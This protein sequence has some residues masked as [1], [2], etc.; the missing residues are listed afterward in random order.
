MIAVV[1]EKRQI[2]AGVKRQTKPLSH[3]KD[4]AMEIDMH[5]LNLHKANLELMLRI[6]N[7]SQDFR[8]CGL[9]AACRYHEDVIAKTRVELDRVAQQCEPETSFSLPTDIFMQLAGASMSGVMAM[10]AP[11]VAA[12]TAYAQGMQKAV[13]EWQTAVVQRALPGS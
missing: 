9:E 1:H 5:P 12:Q 7:L 4:S 6:L 3:R 2:K 8:H 13:Q 10:G 11:L